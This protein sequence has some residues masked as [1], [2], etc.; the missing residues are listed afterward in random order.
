M[1]KRKK[2]ETIAEFRKRTSSTDILDTTAGD[3]ML[4]INASDEDKTI[5]GL[6]TL[7][8]DFRKSDNITVSWRIPQQ[9]MDH[10]KTIAREEGLKKSEDIHYQKLIMGCFLEKHPIPE[11]K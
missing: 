7:Q 11:D 9:V 4:D 1:A 6:L 5:E 2:N 3:M 8:R 10:A